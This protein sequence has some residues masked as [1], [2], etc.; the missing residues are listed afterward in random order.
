MSTQQGNAAPIIIKRK[1]VVA[2]GGH[3]GGAWKV[4]YADF[5]TAMMAFFLLMWLLN[6]TTEKQ[7]K[8]IA[9]FFNPTIPINRISGGGDG[10]LGGD[11]IFTQETMARNGTGAT[12]R[13]Q[14]TTGGF[15][16]PGLQGASEET[17]GEAVAEMKQEVDAML[18]GATGESDVHPEAFKHII[19]KVTDEGVVLEL[20]DQPGAPL[21]EDGSAEPTPMAE[22]LSRILPRVMRIVS[23]A[24]A[25]EG[26]V[27]ARPIVMSR[28]PVWE[29]STE[30]ADVFRKLMMKNGLAPERAA[31]IT[32]HADREPVT[33]DP[34]EARNNR[35]EVILL[36]DPKKIR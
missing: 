2:G 28:N 22:A 7:R 34:M 25:V 35:L 8:G 9:D 24:V 13:N 32:G 29:L 18:A 11:S 1:K 6:A 10:A 4:A 20:F 31:R 19:T 16:G 17:E 15:G 36:R 12:A 27:A 5:V 33:R 30:R 14:E 3:H 26:H 21:F 23:N